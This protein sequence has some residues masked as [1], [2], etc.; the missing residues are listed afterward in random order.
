MGPQSQ[1]QSQQTSHLPYGH[2]MTFC[3]LTWEACYSESLHVH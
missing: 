2:V 1:L 3:G